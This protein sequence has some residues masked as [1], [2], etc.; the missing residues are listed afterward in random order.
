LPDELDEG[1]LEESPD[2]LA[3]F[4]ECCGESLFGRFVECIE[5]PHLS[6]ERWAS[7]LSKKSA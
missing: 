4:P 1:C 7:S 5:M 3:I 2:A 6:G